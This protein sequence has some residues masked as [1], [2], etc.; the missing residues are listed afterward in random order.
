MS[1][2]AVG[3]R[4]GC[5]LLHGSHVWWCRR[6]SP[7]PF[8]PVMWHALRAMVQAFFGFA[9]DYIAHIVVRPAAGGLR[10]SV[11]G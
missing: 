10:T 8:K 2:A 7:T 9:D 3:L 6:Y 1:V 4:A 11:R 5:G